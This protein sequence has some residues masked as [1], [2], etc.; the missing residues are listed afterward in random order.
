MGTPRPARDATKVEAT[1]NRLTSY[2]LH[3]FS[4]SAVLL[5]LRTTRSILRVM[6]KGARYEAIVRVCNGEVQVF[7]TATQ[8][9]NP[10]KFPLR[11]RTKGFEQAQ[12]ILDR[13][14]ANGVCPQWKAENEIRLAA[15]AA[16]KAE[17][18]KTKA[19]ITRTRKDP[20]GHRV[21]RGSRD[22]GDF[23]RRQDPR[24][25]HPQGPLDPGGRDLHPPPHLQR[26]ARMNSTRTRLLMSASL[27]AI[28]ISPKG[29][30]EDTTPP[31][32]LKTTPLPEEPEPFVIGMYDYTPLPRFIDPPK[33][34]QRHEG[35]QSW[36]TAFPDVVRGRAPKGKG[37][38]RVGAKK[39]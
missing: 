4:A 15:E 16:K 5:N 32:H 30:P 26:G 38:S 12:K 34:K 23:P 29:E 2:L 9:D 31:E 19:A 20:E 36:K 27:L 39:R 18:K 8:M 1:A 10:D 28:A 25:H 17:E 37:P 24:V 7:N 13:V 21:L 35:D 14:L 6:Y 22:S 11:K 33:R 3:G